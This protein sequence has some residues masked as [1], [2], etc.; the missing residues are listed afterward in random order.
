MANIVFLDEYSLN[1]ADLNGIRAL[2][3]YTGYEFTAP[4]QVLERA[5]N[6]DILIVNKVKLTADIIG[7]LPKLRLI[8]EAATGVDNIDVQAAGR[9]RY[10]REKCQRILHPLRC[11]SHARRRDSHA[12]RNRLLR[13][14]RQTGRILL[15]SAA[16]QLRP[17]H[18]ATVRPQMGYRRA[19]S[20]RSCRGG[21]RR[22]FRMR[23]GLPFGIGEQAGGEIP[24]N[25]ING[26]IEVGGYSV[27]TLTA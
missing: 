7:N 4:E 9:T 3:N 10:S 26:T 8:C 18:P 16:L 22:R 6:A 23:S 14:F 13:R 1:D 21:T 5:A 19:R 2:G 12:A 15:L 11:G 20:H 24:R 17:P 27:H 25:G